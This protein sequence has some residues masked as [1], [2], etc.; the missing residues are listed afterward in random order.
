MSQATKVSQINHLEANTAAL[1][2]TGDIFGSEPK[3]RLLP[4]NFLET[5]NDLI[6]IQKKTIV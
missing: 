4:N 6:F 3:M 5:K 1:F 2:Y